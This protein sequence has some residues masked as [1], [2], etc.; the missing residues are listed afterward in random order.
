M[1]KVKQADH[2]HSRRYDNERRLRVN[3]LV[4]I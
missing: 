1:E 4:A 3:G 2:V